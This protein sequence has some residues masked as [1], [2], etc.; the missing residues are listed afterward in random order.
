LRGAARGTASFVSVPRASVHRPRNHGHPMRHR[1]IALLIAFTGSLN[2]AD[3]PLHPRIAGDW[4][5]I[6]GDP[7]LGPLTTPEQQP[8]DFGIWPAAD[9]TWQL[10]SCIR[11]TKEP[12]KTRLFHRW[13]G[14]KLTD[15]DWTAKGIAM[16]AD[17]ALGETQ[18]GL[19]APFALR[20]DGKYWLFYGDWQNTCL[21]QSADGK[22]FT[23]WKNDAG[24]PQVFTGMDGARNSR[25]PMVLRVGQKWH[26][27]YTAHPANKGAVY[28]RVSDDLLHWGEEKTVAAGGK[29]GDGPY[30]AECPFVVEP[31]PGHFYLFRT[32]HYGKNAQTMVYHSRDPLSFGINEDEAHYVATLPIA[33]PEIFQHEGK[34]FVAALLPSLKGI[35][36]ATMEWEP[37]ANAA[38]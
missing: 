25:D 6:A 2:A 1:S 3:A 8:V 15:R 30:T 23:R 7:D 18:G 17:P 11:K 29:A 36:I 12:G 38:K 31:K 28:A 26:C 35:Q 20:H 27:Y 4:W 37:A 10:W 9:G 24:K 21:A 32:Q 19:Q 16:Q 34:W 33:A 22:N 5:T 14:A 13:E